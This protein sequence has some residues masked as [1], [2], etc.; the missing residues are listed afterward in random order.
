MQ[1]V[2]LIV[3]S[4]LIF[5][6]MSFSLNATSKKQAPL[7]MHLSPETCMAN[8]IYYEAGNQFVLGK[9]AIGRVIQNR[10]NAGSKNGFA[11]NVCGV[12]YQGIEKHNCQFRFGCKHLGK[13]NKNQYDQCMIIAK[14]V[15]YGDEYSHL[16]TDNVLYFN[17]KK[18]GLH[19]PGIK[20]Y[21]VIGGHV[22]YERKQRL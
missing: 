8:A 13:V 3:V 15:L 4:S 16:F 11:N 19:F 22:F 7:L 18:A 9:A 20:R 14:Q 5:L 21:A 6:G 10:V 2:K 1:K 17:G 12:V